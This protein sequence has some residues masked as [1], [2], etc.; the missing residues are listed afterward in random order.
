MRERWLET[1]IE[2]GACGRGMLPIRR[3]AAAMEVLSGRVQRRQRRAHGRAATCEVEGAGEKGDKWGFG[4][5]VGLLAGVLSKR[6]KA[7]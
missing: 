2:R 5:Q 6:P 1:L 4:G 7:A 3:S